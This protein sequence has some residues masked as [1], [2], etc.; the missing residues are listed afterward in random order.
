[1]A[2]ARSPSI[3]GRTT[4][5]HGST[6]NRLL[7]VLVGVGLERVLLLDDLR[8]AR[9]ARAGERGQL[10]L[11]VL[12]RLA[13]GAAAGVA[14]L[15]HL[16]DLGVSFGGAHGGC[17]RAATAAGAHVAVLADRKPTVADVVV[18]PPA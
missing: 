5:P 3:H 2:R 6:T 17:G 9:R 11:D 1:M 15:E 14:G 10:R 18:E 12:R 16:A 13:A 7:V 4:S 8:I